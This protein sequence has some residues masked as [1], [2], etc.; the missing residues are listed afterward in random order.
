MIVEVLFYEK[1]FTGSPAGAI[2]TRG[3]ASSEFVVVGIE[4]LPSCNSYKIGTIKSVRRSKIHLF[5]A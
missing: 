3:R 5:R 4:R 1:D 2:I